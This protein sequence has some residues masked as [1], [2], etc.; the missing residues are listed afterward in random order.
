MSLLKNITYKVVM[1]VKHDIL[2]KLINELH[3]LQ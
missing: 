3:K 2:K 1:M